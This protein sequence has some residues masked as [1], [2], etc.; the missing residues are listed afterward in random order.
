MA[1]S[2]SAEAGII[3][4]RFAAR[5]KAVPFPLVADRLASGDVGRE[6][7][8]AEAR[9]YCVGLYAALEAPLFHGSARVRA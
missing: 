6:A 2:L 5:L 4:Q 8:G 7:V 9:W 3:R 1:A